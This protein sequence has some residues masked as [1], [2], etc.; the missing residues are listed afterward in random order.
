MKTVIVVMKEN[1]L[2]HFSK[3][4]Q[5]ETKAGYRMINAC[6]LFC[7]RNNVFF[8]VYK[9]ASLFVKTEVYIFDITIL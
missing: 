5:R 3:K 8:N 2:S 9:K 4:R 1:L 7:F 6:V